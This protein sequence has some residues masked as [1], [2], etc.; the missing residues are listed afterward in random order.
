MNDVSQ[1]IQDIDLDQ[2]LQSLVEMYNNTLMSILDKHAPLQTKEVTIR[3]DTPWTAEEIKPLKRKR[4]KLE[5][6]SR[7]T[8]LSV[9]KQA[10]RD[11]NREYNNYLDNR[12]SES[13]A[14]LIEENS[15]DPKTLF[16]VINKAIHRTGQP[17]AFG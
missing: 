1:R 8:G 6:Q 9:H 4:R 16:R 5:R 7:R 3:E 13:Y 11:F 10:L 14:K 12:R 15:E 17:N 2:D